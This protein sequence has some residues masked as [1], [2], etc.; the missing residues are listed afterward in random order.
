M[1]A[2]EALKVLV[3]Q[4]LGSGESTLISHPEDGFYECDVLGGTIALAP[5]TQ[6]VGILAAM[7]STVANLHA[8]TGASSSYTPT[9]IRVRSDYSGSGIVSTISSPTCD[10]PSSG[11]TGCVTTTP[12]LVTGEPSTK[13]SLGKAWTVISWPLPKCSPVS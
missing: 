4:V 11:L 7:G 12:A 5:T 2:G 1:E 10:R 13:P 3:T 8:V 9:A 6:Q